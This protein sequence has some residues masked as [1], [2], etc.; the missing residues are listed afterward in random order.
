MSEIILIEFVNE[1]NDK[2]LNFEIIIKEKLDFSM[3]ER[4]IIKSCNNLMAKIL[5]EF[6]NNLFSD[7]DFL[8]KL[9]STAGRSCLKYLELE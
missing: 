4:E 9:K 7:K 8:N 6:L 1:I 3:L 5:E 2:M